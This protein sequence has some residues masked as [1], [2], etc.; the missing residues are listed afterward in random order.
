MPAA[1]I[2]DPPILIDPAGYSRQSNAEINPVLFPL[3][4][5][6]LYALLSRNIPAGGQLTNAVNPW[7]STDVAATW[8]AQDTANSPGRRDAWYSDFR[9]GTIKAAIIDTFANIRV[10]PF[11]TATNLWGSTSPAF[12][13]PDFPKNEGAVLVDKP[14]GEAVYFWCD[15]TTQALNCTVLAAGAWGAR[16]ELINF[17]EGSGFL[18]G[19]KMQ[20]DGSVHLAKGRGSDNTLSYI[21]VSNG[22]VADAPVDIGFEDGLRADFTIFGSTL[23][24]TW[25]SLADNSTHVALGTPL[26]APVFTDYIVETATGTATTAYA[27]I[28]LNLAGKP[29]AR[30]AY[31]D[32]GGPSPYIDE[33]HESAFDGSTWSPPALFYDAV[34]NP[35]AHDVPPIDQFIHTMQVADQ[36]DNGQWIAFI[37]LEIN[38]PPGSGEACAGLM[39]VSQ[40]PEL[41]VDLVFCGVIRFMIRDRVA[42]GAVS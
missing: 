16:I 5:T 19:G 29:V 13:L 31:W 17:G 24:I 33:I 32:F 38:I 1:V 7:R 18:L 21:R 22:L 10:T 30:W 26:S 27:A 2:T 34:A 28:S 8:A 37:G 4:R 15:Q 6:N 14:N 41:E 23:G 12:A 36:F 11:T 9:A 3:S 35:P 39:L 42:K 25:T 40:A 20:S